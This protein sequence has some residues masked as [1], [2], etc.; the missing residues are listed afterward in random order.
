MKP[1]TREEIAA[2]LQKLGLQSGQIVFVH[3]S[4]SSI[5][6][7]EGGADTVVDAFLSVLGSAGTLVVPT[8]TFSHDRGST[9]V[10]EPDKAPSEMGRIT[11][12]TRTRPGARRSCHLLHSV[13][14]LGAH[15]EEITAVHGPSAWA[16]DG[17]FW[18]LYEL[19]THILMLGVPYLRCTFFHVVEQLVQVRYRRWSEVNA[20]VRDPNGRE[21]PLL[22]LVY[23]P[24]PGF[25]GND[26]NKLGRLLEDRGLAQVGGVGNAVARLFRARDALEVGL[27]EYRKDPFLF[28]MTEDSYTPLR[29]G[30]LTA[31]L[32]NE[33]SVLSAAQIYRGEQERKY[34]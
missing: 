10:F 21:Q 5:G 14:A 12:V 22:T 15:A 4:L 26:F 6:Y 1:L 20:R 2:T 34:R 29:D 19:D 24:K 31:E 23:S 7:V 27:A 3:S 9:P 16:A 30:V 17:P 8:F 33:K 11:E 18:K 28:V 13:A 25:Q 32:H